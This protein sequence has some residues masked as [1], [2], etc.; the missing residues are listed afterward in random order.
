M[1]MQELIG[2]SIARLDRKDIKKLVKDVVQI[3]GKYWGMLEPE[4]KLQYLKVMQ[5]ILQDD[6][7]SDFHLGDDDFQAI[8]LGRL[9][10]VIAK[11]TEL[12]SDFYLEKDKES[13]DKT[14]DF[15]QK[16][17][18]RSENSK[19]AFL[20][21]ELLKNTSVYQFDPNNP[22]S[23]SRRYLA[24]DADKG[25]KSKYMYCRACENFQ[26]TKFEIRKDG[27]I[28]FICRTPKC[29]GDFT[30]HNPNPVP[31]HPEA[32]KMFFDWLDLLAEGIE[33]VKK[34]SPEKQVLSIL[35]GMAPNTNSGWPFFQSQAKQLIPGMW[36]K[37]VFKYA[38]KT[39]KKHK[40]W[41]KRK[42]KYIF[43]HKNK[44]G[45]VRKRTKT[46]SAGL[47]VNIILDVLREL[48]SYAYYE[49]F[50]HF[51]RTQI[52][53]D[54]KV[55]KHRSVFG[56]GF[57]NKV[58]GGLLAAAKEYAETV[59]MAQKLGQYVPPNWVGDKFIPTIGNLPF[60]AQLNWD[61]LFSMLKRAMPEVKLEED[62]DGKTHGT[63]VPMTNVEIYEIFGIKLPAGEYLVDVTG[64]DFPGY[65]QG[66]IPEDINWMRRHPKLGWILSWILDCLEF[67]EVWV[68][69]YRL[70]DIFYKS[71]HPLTS[72]IGSGFH[73]Q[74]AF[75]VR[76]FIK[77]I[78]NPDVILL[79]GSVLSDDSLFYWIGFQ[80]KWMSEY[81]K[82]YG[83][84]I[85]ET[86]S[87][88]YSR[89]FI[90]EFLKV[91]IGYVL[92]DKGI[93]VVGD[94]ISRE[95]GFLHSEKDVE[96]ELYDNDLKGVYEITGDIEVDSGTSK[97]ASYN[98]DGKD[99]VY[100][101]LQSISDTP[102]G[103]KI[104]RA[105][106]DMDPY[107]VRPYRSD[108]VVSFP[109]HWMKRVFTNLRG[110]LIPQQR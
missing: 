16:L 66:I 34:L 31:E 64:E 106:D 48:I 70:R 74:I 38:P 2:S 90:V 7:D 5:L 104:I 98:V 40:K 109:P 18:D 32:T 83:L 14:F 110:L 20:A 87:F 81:L 101:K 105:I 39:F 63:L 52:S 78:H 94:P 28:V 107:R 37:F 88:L 42:F 13:K 24:V 3:G 93:V 102:L 46:I 95:L 84:R 21:Q 80:L 43:Y 36:D 103:R 65:D 6:P 35:R 58:L 62:D 19:S 100:V 85:K 1:K 60:M 26:P 79:G 92:R 41:F 96:E 50:A 59:L 51:Y 67:G 82:Q 12:F 97:A 56:G 22:D 68:G 57:M 11:W 33:E 25:I 9:P 10:E 61:D 71:G 45:K 30:F 73:W 99:L 15:P 47:Q 91:L 54:R 44:L 76:D 29:R 89:D 53:D 23:R 69:G 108:V 17:I 8:Q 86:D 75:N 77:K 27:S 4:D 72:P 49:V 55:P